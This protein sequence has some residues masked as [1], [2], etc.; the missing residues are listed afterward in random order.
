MKLFAWILKRYG[1]G[2]EALCRADWSQS[3]DPIPEVPGESVEV[4]FL[5]TRLIAWPLESHLGH[6]QRIY[7]ANF[8]I[9]AGGPVALQSLSLNRRVFH[10]RSILVLVPPT[11]FSPFGSQCQ[12]DG[13]S[14]LTRTWLKLIQ[15]NYVLRCFVHTRR[16]VP[17]LKSGSCPRPPY[18]KTESTNRR[19]TTADVMSKIRSGL[20]GL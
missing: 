19:R 7:K 1:S 5:P 10:C 6:R 3:L 15:N 9:A 4:T 18:R 8:R 11:S 12:L 2:K 16:V 14:V 20:D 17:N 13:P